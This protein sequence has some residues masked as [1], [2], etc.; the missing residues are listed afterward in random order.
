MGS[1]SVLIILY[2]A[3]GTFVLGTLATF[4]VGPS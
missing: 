3:P 1:F 2:F 4:A